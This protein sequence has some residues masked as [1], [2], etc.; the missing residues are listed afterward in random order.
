MYRLVSNSEFKTKEIA[1][2]LASK[3]CNRDIIVLSR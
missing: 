3:L 1:S 2:I